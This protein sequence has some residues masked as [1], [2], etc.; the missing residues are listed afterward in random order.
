MTEAYRQEL[1]SY[2]FSRF[3]LSDEQMNRMLPELFAT[4]GRHMTNLEEKLKEGDL[5][6]LGRAGHTMKG[7]LLN[8][9]LSQCAEIAYQ[10]EIKGKSGAVDA[11][12]TGMVDS[13]RRLIDNYLE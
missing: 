9:G 2:L 6:Q 7:A 8:L 1:K 3:N 5:E 4:L 10:I 12:F 11:D 13:M